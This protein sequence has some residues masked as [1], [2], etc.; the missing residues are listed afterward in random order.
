[1]T[2][3][4]YTTGDIKYIAT[5][6]RALGMA[7]P[8]CRIGWTV[9]IIVMD[10]IENRKRVTLE[11]REANALY[12]RNSSVFSE[13][14]QKRRLIKH[15][16]PDIIWVCSLGVRNLLIYNKA[17][18]FIEHSELGS[19]IPDN[20]GFKKMLIK[21]FEYFSLSHS[22]L[23][24]AS[25]YLVDYFTEK[26]KKYSKVIPV[27]YSP[28]AY[29]EDVINMPLKIA[30]QLKSAYGGVTNF[31]FMGTLTR[32]YGLF[33]MLEAAKRLKDTGIRFHLLILG[34]GRHSDGAKEFI[35]HNNLED[36][37]AMTGYV[38]ET[39]LSSYFHLADAFISPLNDTVQDRAR[40]PSKIYM[41]LPFKKPILTCAIGEAENIFGEN[42]LYFDNN[43]PGT[44]CVLMEKICMGMIKIHLINFEK[45]SWEERAKQFDTWYKTN[46]LYGGSE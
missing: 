22:G 40:C 7:N 26:I 30:K 9:Y 8:L 45:H 11:A 39:C 43:D 35:I 41:Y 3:C 2:I 33:T 10:S 31:L 5:I 1:M 36:C 21:F 4:F 23:I 12:Y 42:G 46:F 18:I 27:H 16:K 6:K 44:L 28:Y 15:I 14:I 34:R 25:I 20:K 37:V 32:N 13:V 24:C 19:A 29:N 17:K 38:D